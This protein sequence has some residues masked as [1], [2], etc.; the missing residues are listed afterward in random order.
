MSQSG[1]RGSKMTPN[2]Q[3][4]MF[5]TIWGHFGPIWTLFG[6]FTQNFSFCSKSLLPRSSLCFIGKKSSFV[7]KDKK[8]SKQSQNGPK[9]SKTCYINHLGSFWTLLDHFGTSTSLPRFAIFGPKGPF[10]TPLHTWLKDG[11]GQNCIKPTWYMSKDY[12]RVTDPQSK[13][14][15]GHNN[16]NRA[17]KGSKMAKNGKSLAKMAL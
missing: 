16:Q 14:V 10:W 15:Y 2:D 12:E 11:N 9:W 3:Y 13:H 1:L 7:W 6:H 4:N 5:L 8:G 17:K